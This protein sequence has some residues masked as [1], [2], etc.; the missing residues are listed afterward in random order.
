M[1]LFVNSDE[2]SILQ[3]QN[4]LL[5]ERVNKI[6]QIPLLITNII[7]ISVQIECSR[8]RKERVSYTNQRLLHARLY[9][10]DMRRNDDFEEA[11]FIFTLLKAFSIQL[12]LNVITTSFTRTMAWKIITVLQTQTVKLQTRTNSTDKLRGV[13]P[14]TLKWQQ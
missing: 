13:Q 5:P 11:F 7:K 14:Y 9:R 2:F 10:E 6:M 4:Y 1:K 12:I 3:Q 8:N